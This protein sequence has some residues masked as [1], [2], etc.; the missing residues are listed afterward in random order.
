M[1]KGDLIIFC[2]ANTM[3]EPDRVLSLVRHFDEPQVGCVCG[4]LRLR[5]IEGKP[6]TEGLYWRYE[7]LLKFLE[8]RLNMLVGGNGAVLG[9]R[10]SLFAPI[11]PNGIIDDFLVAMHVV[12]SGHHLVYDPEAVAWEEVAPNVRQEFRRRVRIGAGNFHALRYTW[13]MLIPVAGSIA[14]S[15]WSHKVSRWLVPVALC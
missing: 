1:T 8:S 9:I 3:L 7:V 10:R 14:F 15:Y 2:D 11:P 5:P 4:E 12:A 13:R 6:S